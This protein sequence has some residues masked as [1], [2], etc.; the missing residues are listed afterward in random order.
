MLSSGP[1]VRASGAS[2][3]LNSQNSNPQHETTHLPQQL[4]AGTLGAHPDLLRNDDMT[5]G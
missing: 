4:G 5:N 1:G 3:S 2:S